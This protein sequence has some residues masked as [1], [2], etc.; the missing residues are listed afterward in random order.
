MCEGLRSPG[1]RP[2][3]SLAGVTP[4]LWMHTLP[5][6][7]PLVSARR[8]GAFTLIE[9]LTVIAVI[10]VLTALVVGV[11]GRVRESAKST[12]CVSNLRQI[13]QAALLYGTDN[14]NIIPAGEELKV[15]PVDGSGKYARF[16]VRLRPYLSSLNNQ[17]AD[18]RSAFSC[19]SAQ[20]APADEGKTINAY[21]VVDSVNGTAGRG[22]TFLQRADPKRPFA[23]DKRI[24]NSPGVLNGSDYVAATSIEYRHG[25]D[26]KAN[27]VFFDGHV[28]AVDAARAATLSW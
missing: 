13:Q 9:L 19:P 26:T 17:R 21:G 2:R 18:A 28:E 10:G 23:A 6:P 27:V 20:I 22:R 24:Y 7:C 1:V 3:A 25:G 15:G 14:R 8:R 11:V 4:P 12:R 5:L 16:E